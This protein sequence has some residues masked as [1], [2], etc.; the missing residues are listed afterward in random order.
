MEQKLAS[1]I[2][3]RDFLKMCGLAIVG[4]GAGQV[5][6]PPKSAAALQTINDDLY[7]T[8]RVG[9]G[10][11]TSAYKLTV[12]SYANHVELSDAAYINHG[13]TDILPTEAFLRIDKISGGAG[14]ASVVA[15]NDAP[16]N[17]ALVLAGVFGV[18][19]PVNAKAAITVTGAKKAA[20]GNGVQA[21]DSLE[22]VL[23]VETGYPT[24]GTKLVTIMGNGS[25]GIGTTGPSYKLDVL[26]GHIH[27]DCNVYV[28]NSIVGTPNPFQ[29]RTNNAFPIQIAPNDV[30]VAHFDPTGKVGIKTA[31]PASYVTINSYDL[32]FA[33]TDSVNINH[34]IT[35]YLLTVDSYFAVDKVSGGGGGA[36][37]KGLND[38]GGNNPVALAGIHGVTDPVSTKAAV[39]ICGSKKNGTG[40]QSLAASET[41]FQVETGIP[42]A[43]SKLLTIMGSGNV[44]IGPGC[45]NPDAQL[46]VIGTA[47]VDGPLY[48]VSPSDPN[49]KIES[50][51]WPGSLAIRVKAWGAVSLATGAGDVLNVVGGNVG[52]GRNNP[53]T[54]LHLHSGALK[55]GSLVVADGS[56]CYYA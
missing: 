40:V 23:Q 39:V 33:L 46:Q 42:T 15:A 50:Y 32:P 8:G 19:D 54:T 2:T 25:V 9:I 56:G 12:D 41:V 22:T 35:D 47:H 55:I 11:S 51:P 16:D 48:F 3:H 26:G 53:D 31:S 4:A 43:G 17:T 14:G 6:V 34:G 7:V 30:V 5:V 44:G 45:T 28:G 37:V 29:I 20:N 10:T 24:A 36:L 49:Y 18:T 13:M 21:L 38:D 1:R 52:I 27:T